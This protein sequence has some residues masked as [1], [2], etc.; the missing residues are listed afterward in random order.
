M[1]KVEYMHEDELAE[2]AIE[3]TNG[4][5]TIPESADMPFHDPWVEVYTFTQEAK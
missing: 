2:L 5:Q 4:D 1:T 3:I